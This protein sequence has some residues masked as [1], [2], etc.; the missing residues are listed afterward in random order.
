MSNKF[1][2]E[3]DEI[4]EVVEI[5]KEEY[6]EAQKDAEALKRLEKNRDFKRLILDGF[7]E[8][9]AVRLVKLKQDPGIKSQERIVEDIDDRITSIGVLNEHLR[10]I[11][12]RA[13]GLKDQLL[14][15][16]EALENAENEDV[17]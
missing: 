8:K 6:D 12:L 10:Y 17:S 7:L 2:N 5:K 9:E 16:E 4:Y 1:T 11:R 15:A 14:E 3:K 13:K